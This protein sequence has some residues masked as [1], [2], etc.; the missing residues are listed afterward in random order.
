M[1]RFNNELLLE[2]LFEDGTSR[3]FSSVKDMNDQSMNPLPMPLVKMN[4]EDNDSDGKVDK[5]RLTL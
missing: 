5:Y 4:R 3:Q 1:V 2:V